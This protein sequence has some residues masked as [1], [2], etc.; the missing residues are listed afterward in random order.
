VTINEMHIAVNLGVQKIASFQVDNFLPQEV[1]HELNIA[2]D[3]FIKQRYNPM[4]NRYQKG[5]EQ[6]QKRIDDLRNLV[7]TTTLTAY[8][9][10][11]IELLDTNE[12]Y[13]DRIALPNDYLFLVNIR[14][15]VLDNCSPATVSE[16]TT[17]LKY[18]RV[19][20]TPPEA[21]YVLTHIGM[22][23]EDNEVIIAQN[24]NGFTYDQ[25]LNEA[26][27]GFNCCSPVVSIEVQETTTFEQT[28]TADSNEFYLKVN[29]ENFPGTLTTTLTWTHPVT[30]ATTQV[31]MES[32]E[33]IAVT[34]RFISPAKA[35]RVV[36]CNFAQ[37][38]DIHILLNDPFNT[39]K[40]TFPKFTFRE[41]FIDIYTNDE[42]VV[43][44]ARVDYIRRPQRMSKSL[45]VG[46]ELPEHTH[47]EIVEMA[48]K[49]ILE[50]VQD[51]RYQSQSIESM[52]SE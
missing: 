6:S 28:P 1:D 13:I 19:S 5:F 22:V 4:S 38:D 27:Y 31:V 18:Q 2:M 52:E 25:L 17:T 35:T 21:G 43:D 29:A 30:G 32:A 44:T 7:V 49:S 51:S 20:L 45:G 14:A 8:S 48:I 47:Q 16:Q 11:N 39:T 36:P 23:L 9:T 50:S 40:S 37:L 3:R 24:N 46:C 34:K 12:F 26:T 33:E 15:S 10:G 41:N 42:F